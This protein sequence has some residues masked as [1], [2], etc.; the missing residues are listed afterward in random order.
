MASQEEG[1]VV[2][3]VGL[4][5]MGAREGTGRG[6][7]MIEHAPASGLYPVVLA[8]ESLEIGPSRGGE[9]ARF[10]PRDIPLGGKRHAGRVSHDAR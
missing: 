9:L 7:P 3:P 10:E 6:L 2:P 5:T 4:L 8:E 1:T